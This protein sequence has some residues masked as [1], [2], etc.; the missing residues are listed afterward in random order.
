MKFQLLLA[1]LTLFCT[2]A[3][4]QS[5]K[6]KNFLDDYLSVSIWKVNH[7]TVPLIRWQDKDTLHYNISGELRYL[8]HKS[9][10]KFISSVEQAT[11]LKIVETSNG[12][13]AEIHIYF[14]SIL[15][16]FEHFNLDKRLIPDPRFNSWNNRQYDKDYA[17]T[18]SSFCIDPTLID[19]PNY[20]IYVLMSSFLKSLGIL[21]R[22]IDEY[23]LFNPG[24]SGSN[25]KLT[26]Y[27][28]RFLKLHYHED[29]RPGMLEDE[30]KSI[31]FDSINLESI[32]KEKF[33]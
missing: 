26:K 18:R 2:H 4:A 9:W 27:D 28:K 21:G 13:D 32:R 15:S 12:S 7:I 33:K 1:F 29:L 8:N 6:D 25:H 20:G 11:G 22:L 14:G 24:Y 16:Y 23:S 31:A 5:N 3:N 19:N 30:I 17:L 10:N